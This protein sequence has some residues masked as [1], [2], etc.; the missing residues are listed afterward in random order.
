MICCEKCF[1]DPEIKGI[2]KCL[3]Q[4]GNCGT[5]HRVN[6]QIYDTE[7]GSDLVESFIKLLSIYT[8]RDSLPDDFPKER[9][10]LLK[11]ISHD[12]WNIFN[13]SSEQIYN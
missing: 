4:E 10:S 7:K 11:D 13:I 9:L 6:V 8:P 12:K 5:C 3:K 2:I 1:K